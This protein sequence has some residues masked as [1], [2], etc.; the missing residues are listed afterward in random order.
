VTASFQLSVLI[1]R[2]NQEQES[3]PDEAW[4]CLVFPEDDQQEMEK[5][6]P[7]RIGDRSPQREGPVVE[8]NPYLWEYPEE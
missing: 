8:G 5:K 7:V 2:M 1:N 6:G 3:S 4:K